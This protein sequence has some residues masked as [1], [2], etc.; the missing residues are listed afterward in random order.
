MPNWLN[1]NFGSAL[2]TEEKIT[3]TKNLASMI[4]AGLTLSR[5]L[6][7]IERQSKKKAMKDIVLDLEAKIR[8]GTSFHEALDAHRKEFSRLFIAMTKAGEE[9]G[10][11]R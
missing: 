9:G 7:V 3:F 6:S 5:A 10:Q 11:A 1:I 2:K 4:S 8:A